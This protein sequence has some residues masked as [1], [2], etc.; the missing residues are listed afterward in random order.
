MHDRFKKKNPENIGEGVVVEQMDFKLSL[1]TDR[2]PCCFVCIT[3]RLPC[4]FV[5]S[6]E[7]VEKFKGKDLLEQL[8][9]E[10]TTE[11][12]GLSQVVIEERD[13]FLA[14]SL[15]MAA[16]PIR[17]PREPKGQSLHCLL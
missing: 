4:C 7:D 10:M 1:L 9:A 5:C 11:F 17:A 8:L 2:P 15:K 3:D 14:H 13:T 12:P 16:E 6:K